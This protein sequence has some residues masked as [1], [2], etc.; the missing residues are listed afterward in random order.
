MREPTLVIVNKAYSSWSMRPWLVMRHF[1]LPFRE[2]VIPMDRPT[3]RSDILAYSPTAKC[4]CLID[5]EITVWESLAIIEYLA[6]CHPAMAIWPAERAA[7]AHARALAAE[8]HSGFQALRQQM[9]MNIRRPVRR[10]EPGPATITDVARLEAV[11][12]D[13]QTRFAGSGP[14]LFGDFSAAD[15]MF[16]PVVN[17]LH[18]YDVAVTPATRAYMDAVMALPAWQAWADGAV[19]ETW[20]I[21]KY[22]AI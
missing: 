13:T 12:A 5:G 3:T 6:E 7:R 22:E 1:G 9:P 8:M 15:A 18:I 21:A 14:F 20:R 10:L 17:R 16:A 2:V 11:F 4:P 19:A